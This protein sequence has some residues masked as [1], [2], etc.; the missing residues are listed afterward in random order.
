MKAFIFSLLFLVSHSTP[1]E[2]HSGVPVFEPVAFGSSKVPTL[3]GKWE[4]IPAV[5]VCPNAPVSRV[6]VER[7]MNIWKRQG[8][9]TAGPFMNSTIPACLKGTYSFG[10]IVID[11]NGQNF[12]DQPHAK[13]AATWTYFDKAT[14]EVLGARIE[15][16][17]KWADKERVL[18]HEFG[19]AFGW[20]HYA[21]RYHL[22]HPVHDIGGWDMTG[23]RNKR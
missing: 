18:E 7:A 5:Y 17:E 11:L 8:F 21:R 22:M 1:P 10:N 15:I 6:R 3:E 13:A 20:K 9:E 14:H 4:M 2:H 12:P 23:L 19:H 16:K